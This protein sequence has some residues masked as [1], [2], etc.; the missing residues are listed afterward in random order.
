MIGSRLRLCGLATT[1][2]LILVLAVPASAEVAREDG[3]IVSFGGAVNPRLLP[4]VGTAPVAVTVAGRVRT[5]DHRLPPSLRRISLEI[6]RNGVLDNRGLPICRARQI[7]PSSSLQALRACGPAKVGG[8]TVSGLVVIPGQPPFGFDGR[9]VAFNARGDHGQPEIL[10]HLFT[11][12]PLALT[13]VLTFAVDRIAGTYGTRLVALVPKRTRR[14]THV[15]SF[16]LHLRRIYEFGGRRH[17]YLSAGCPAPE[18]FPGA[19]FPLVR[20]SYSF[21]GGTQL[22]SVLVR[23]CHARA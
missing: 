19:T 6:N 8:G 3:V 12:S 2:A 17:S 23:T 4:R 18:G 5:A 14:I 20:A 11:K 16:T 15:T 7:Q 13:F 1:L 22:S 10:A 21:D 9:V